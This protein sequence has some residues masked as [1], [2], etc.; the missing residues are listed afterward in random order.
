M[1]N[2]KDFSFLCPTPRTV[3][4]QNGTLDIQSLC[5]PLEIT[6]KYDFLFDHFA[7]R[8]KN[9]G[10]EI[11]CQEKKT[12][13]AEEYVVECEPGRVILS[14][15]SPRGRFYA[16]STLMQILAHFQPEGRMPGF[17]IRDAP[18]MSFRGFSLDMAYGAI[19]L[20]DEMRRL[21]LRL[22][23]LKFNFVSLFLG[24]PNRLE[25]AAN[26]E[27][28]RG[29]ITRDEIDRVVALGA[30]MALDV[31]PSIEIGPVAPGP[32]D[33]DA[34]F[35]AAFGSMWV[36][37]R[38]D[39]KKD[40]EPAAAW[41]SRF[42]GCYHFF[43]ARGKKLLVRGEDFL[44]T[45]DW[46]RKIPQDVMVLIAADEIDSSAGFKRAAG[47]FKRHHLPQVLGTSTWSQARLIPAMRRSTED[48][49]AALAAV[50]EEKLAGVMLHCL[51]EQGDG[52]FLE[53]ILL[54]LFQ[55]G[56]LF[57]DGQS[58]RPD[59]FS[60]WALGGHD[61][62]LFR[63]YAFLSQVDSP[64]QHS[65]WQYL[66][67]DPLSA[68]CSRQ[69]DVKEIT[70]RYR[71]ASLYLKKRKIAGNEVSDFLHIAQS[72]YEFVADK[73]EFSGRLMSW[74]ETAGGDESVRQALDRLL[75]ACEKLKDLYCA[76]WLKRRHPFGLARRIREFDLIQERFSWIRRSMNHPA[77]KKKLAM[78][79]KN[80]SLANGPSA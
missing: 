20:P 56:N 5:F 3:R 2:K 40:D 19:P 66:F 77:Q 47:P 76:M 24:D 70:A 45:P 6:K 48:N 61:P 37:V 51:T 11:T 26:S 17:L 13:A 10:L 58:P 42:M 75:P 7:I 4:P 14:A 30:M 36:Q 72:V 8:N 74:L 44:K 23:L 33:L 25:K 41:F 65:H 64:L 46:I 59:A 1:E 38:L 57:W 79:I 69:D 68:A 50:Q 22:A 49:A 53:G 73:V 54:P 16:L 34:G 21:L 28:P 15:N 78:Q 12:L 67:E 29:C 32:D 39:E 27:L 18:T 71:K 52:A 63:V 43:R 60:Q 35:L 31:L 9:R 80:H 62:D 55:S